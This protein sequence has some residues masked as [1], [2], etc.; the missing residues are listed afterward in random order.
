MG[1]EDIFEGKA[2][3]DVK[4]EIVL[5]LLDTDNNLDEKTELTKPMRWSCLV[6]MKDYIGGLNL[7]KSEGILGQFIR[8]SH[9]FLIS[10]DREGRKEYI[11]SLRALGNMEH[12][13][14]EK[15]KKNNY[16]MI[17]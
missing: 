12:E 5:E 16:G 14:L 8:Q 17:S 15:S 10:K 1:L 11:E 13:N 7:G 2:N 6:V 3:A 4:R 9:K